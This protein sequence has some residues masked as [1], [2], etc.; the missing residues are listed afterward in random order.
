MVCARRSIRLAGV[1]AA[2][3]CGEQ[4]TRPRTETR[5]AQCSGNRMARRQFPVSGQFR[6]M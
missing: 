3:R 5:A 2:S 6:F 4:P 1:V